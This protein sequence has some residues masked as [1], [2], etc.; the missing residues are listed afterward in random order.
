MGIVYFLL[1]E[2]RELNGKCA[3]N[4]GITHAQLATAK[5]PPVWWEIPIGC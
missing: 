1:F 5:Q 3:L 2:R 4:V